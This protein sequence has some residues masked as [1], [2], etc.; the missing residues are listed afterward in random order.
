VLIDDLHDLNEAVKWCEVCRGHQPSTCDDCRQ[1]FLPN[2]TRYRS[3]SFHFHPGA[4]AGTAGVRSVQKELCVDCYRLDFKNVSP[5]LPL[6]DLPDRGIDPRYHAA[7][8]TER[9]RAKVE[10]MIGKLAACDV[11]VEDVALLRRVSDV[12]LRFM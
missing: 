7:Q 2:E 8:R 5:D 11:A 6:P 3:Q 9:H 4:I 12:G 1:K 10:E